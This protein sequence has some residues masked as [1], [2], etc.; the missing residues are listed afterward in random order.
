MPSWPPI[1][2]SGPREGAFVDVNTCLF[3]FLLKILMNSMLTW[4]ERCPGLGSATFSIANPAGLCLFYFPTKYFPEKVSARKQVPG[5]QGFHVSQYGGRW[6]FSEN[7]GNLLR[8][9]CAL[10]AGADI[11]YW[12][13][14][15]FQVARTV[16]WG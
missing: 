15:G 14:T 4:E 2:L 7:W 11:K 3:F 12:S 6:P 10:V 1:G 13:L 16:I 5:W 8:I 9:Y